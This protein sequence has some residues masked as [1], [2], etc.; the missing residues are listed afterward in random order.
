MNA[1]DKEEELVNKHRMI[2][3]QSDADLSEEIQCSI[4]AKQCALISVNEMI[5]LNGEL[6]LN[7]IGL[8]YYREKN[9]YLF[10]DKQEIEKL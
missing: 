9:A 10:D 4:I 1:K 3:M 7:S 6:Y 8:D 5:K 2:L